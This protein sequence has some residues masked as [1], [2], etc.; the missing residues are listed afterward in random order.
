MGEGLAKEWMMDRSD[1]VIEAW[2]RQLAAMDAGDTA[3]L[4]EC[5]TDDAHLVH[6][7]GYV[8]PLEEWM[9]EMRAGKFVYHEVIEQGAEVKVDGETAVLDGRAITGYRSDGSGQAWPLR[10]RQS[11]RL[12]EGN[13]LCEESRVTLQQP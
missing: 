4:A 2:Q 6:M 12:V 13:W 10:M 11:Y 9:R 5:F 1:E 8:Q 7:T 3:A